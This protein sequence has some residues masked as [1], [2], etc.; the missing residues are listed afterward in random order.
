MRTRSR[1]ISYSLPPDVLASIL[2][3]TDGGALACLTENGAEFSVAAEAALDDF[4]GN[5]DH[6]HHVTVKALLLFAVRRPLRVPEKFGSLENAFA[7][8]RDGDTILISENI[9][10]P[11]DRPLRVPNIRLRILGARRP[12]WTFG[13]DTA[14]VQ[15][16]P[17]KRLRAPDVW[18]AIRVSTSTMDEAALK[19]D[20]DQSFLTVQNIAFLGLSRDLGND[21]WAQDEDEDDIDGVMGFAMDSHDTAIKAGNGARVHVDECAFTGYGRVAVHATCGGSVRVRD[22]YV[23]RGFFCALAEGRDASMLLQNCRLLGE[24]SY[25]ACSTDGGSMELVNCRIADHYTRVHSGATCAQG[26]GSRM[27]VDMKT[28]HYSRHPD[29]EPAP[30]LVAVCEGTMLV[31]YHHLTAAGV[32]LDLLMD[33]PDIDL[34]D[35]AAEPP[36]A[37]HWV[38]IKT[39]AAFELYEDHIEFGD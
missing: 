26:E 29:V 31:Q 20:G 1:R 14:H 36:P 30:F 17:R 4:S 35:P 32:D 39:D 33:H 13:S 7:A 28:T 12:R 11:W 5:N 24:C 27:K 34:G 9:G 6:P 22:S 10:L 8:A 38:T 19:I 15:R 2:S 21:T 25:A 37:D 3:F 23:S 18:K 16:M